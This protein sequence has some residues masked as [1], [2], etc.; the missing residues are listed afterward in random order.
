MEDLIMPT[1]ERETIVTPVSDSGPGT[2]LA[3][4]LALV[5]VG[6]IGYAI[7]AFNHGAI[8]PTVT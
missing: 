4:L 5:L 8:M 6:V 2:F 3:V 7:Y 1:L